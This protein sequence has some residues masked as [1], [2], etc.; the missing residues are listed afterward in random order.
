M[1]AWTTRQLLLACK[2]L[3]EAA[4][5]EEFEIDH[6]SLRKT[7]THMIGNI[8]V[9]TDLMFQRP[10]ERRQGDSIVELLAR[11]GTI[12]RDFHRLTAKIVREQRWD[13]GY[14]DVLEQ[15]PKWRTFGGTIGH[16]ITH[17][18]H[19]RA[20]VMYLMEKVGTQGAHRG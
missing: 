9:W 19:H 3:P 11:L 20:Q 7:F 17:N 16:V 18:M 2:G 12:S 1:T 4:L 13:D 8:E 10:I 15:P 5:D 6:R 14:L